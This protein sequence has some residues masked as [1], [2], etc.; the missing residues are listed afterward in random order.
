MFTPIFGVDV[1]V[2]LAPI[3]HHQLALRHDHL[4]LIVQERFQVITPIRQARH[5]DHMCRDP[6]PKI[7]P[8]SS[9]EVWVGAS[10]KCFTMLAKPV[11]VRGRDVGAAGRFAGYG[12]RRL[13]TWPTY[14]R[15]G[16]AEG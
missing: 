5:V 6:R 11:S 8:N 3:F 10:G 1:G 2:T 4:D 16:T 12:D 14:Y 9:G 15:R 7:L 13:A